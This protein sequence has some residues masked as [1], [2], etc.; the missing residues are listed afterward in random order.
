[1]LHSPN[2]L[3]QL[4]NSAAVVQKQAQYIN[5]RAWVCFNTLL[6]MDTEI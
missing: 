1:M 4:L 6:F 3:S 2:G 5:K